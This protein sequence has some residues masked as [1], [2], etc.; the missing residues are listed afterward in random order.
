MKKKSIVLSAIGAGT[1][2]AGGLIF[3][4]LKPDV[5]P[6]KKAEI[7]SSYIQ[8]LKEAGFTHVPSVASNANEEL[9]FS[10]AKKGFGFIGNDEMENLLSSN[11]LL[12]APADKFKDEIPENAAKMFAGNFDRA[13]KLGAIKDWIA[14]DN[15]AWSNEE[16]SKMSIEDASYVQRGSKSS[17]YVCAHLES[18]N[19]DDMVVV[20]HELKT[21]NNDPIIVAKVDGGYIELARWQSK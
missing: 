13:K 5:I 21:A 9:R 19:T 15:R 17:V 7:P 3:T 4:G 8:T 10:W 20:G 18:L 16:V 6:E 12:I 11:D 1:V 14:P 2:V